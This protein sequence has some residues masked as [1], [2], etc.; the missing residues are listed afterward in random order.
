[1][2][3]RTVQ[4]STYEKNYKDKKTDEWKSVKINL[5][6]VGDRLIQFRE[7][8]ANSK[9]VSKH[10]FEDNGT[11]TM[12]VYIW[13]DK[14]DAVYHEGQLI[15]DSSDANGTA[16]DITVKNGKY[17]LEVVNK[18]LEKLETVATGRALANLGYMKDGQI[19]STE[20]MEQF[21]QYKA[22]RK[23]AEQALA[24]KRLEDCST[25]DQLRTEF[26][27]LGE[28]MRDPE[29]VKVKDAMKAKLEA[30]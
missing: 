29:V 8:H 23:Q 26:A 4:L 20:E 15:L 18:A 21:E 12:R 22:E 16:N 3:R 11:T 2:N 24:V 13:K 6:F 7:D 9:I 28:L 5:A 10:K 1:M 25:L 19:A 27:K 14:K 17:G 30:K